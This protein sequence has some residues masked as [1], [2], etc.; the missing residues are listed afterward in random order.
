MGNAA[1]NMEVPHSKEGKAAAVMAALTVT[2][3]STA[4]QKQGAGPKLPMP[5][6]NELEQRF[7]AV[8]V[9]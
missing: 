8:L 3:G 1:G 9:S 4:P 7:S 5:P 6:E 2:P